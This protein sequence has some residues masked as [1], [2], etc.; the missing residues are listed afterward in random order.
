MRKLTVKDFK[1][2]KSGTPL[3]Y[4]I[5]N[6]YDY[7]VYIKKCGCHIFCNKFGHRFN[8]NHIKYNKKWV[9]TDFSNYYE[10]SE[11]EYLVKLLES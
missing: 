5:L 9:I 7:G 10:L 8:Q 3:G 11:E 6:Q 4:K 1:Y 2:L